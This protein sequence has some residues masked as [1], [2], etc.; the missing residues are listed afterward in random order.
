LARGRKKTVK[1]SMG[2]FLRNQIIGSE[3]PTEID[4]NKREIHVMTRL[5]EDV[6]EILDALVG[7][8]VFKSRSEAVSAFVENSLISNLEVY[9][10]VREQFKE[11]E[12]KRD[13]AMETVID[14][15]EKFD[16]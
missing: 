15:F 9:L 4:I 7:L 13:E 3:K 10:T 16:K 6:I 5:S 8:N 14:A 1:S 11:V 2:E 12:N